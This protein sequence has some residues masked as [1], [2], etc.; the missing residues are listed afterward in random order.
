MHFDA[1]TLAERLH[2]PDGESF[3]DELVDCVA[4]G[5][6]VLEI[7][8]HDGTK[9]TWGDPSHTLHVLR[10]LGWSAGGRCVQ[11]I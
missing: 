2:S 9:R 3:G 7:T 10:E 8:F 6:D 5:R 1:Q 4:V 11:E